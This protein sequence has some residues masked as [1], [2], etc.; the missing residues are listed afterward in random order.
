VGRCL[1]PSADQVKRTL[2]DVSRLCNELGFSKGAQAQAQGLLILCPWHTEKTP[3]CSVTLSSDRTVRVKCFACG[4]SGDVL[5][6]IARARGLDLK[7]EFRQVL[8]E[9][10]RI[11]TAVSS[12]GHNAGALPPKADG[13]D[14][15]DDADGTLSEALASVAE[16]LL[17]NC[18]LERARQ[19]CAYLEARGLIEEA[20][21][22]GW[23]A[24]PDDP[25]PLVHVV[26]RVLM[27]HGADV[28]QRSGF[29]GRGG[30][31]VWP[32]HRVLIPWRDPSGRVTT[33][34]RRLARRASKEERAYVFPRGGAAEWP[35]GVDT[36]LAAASVA[37]A[38]VEGAFDALA[39]RA[40]YRK[41]HVQRVVVGV[42][43]VANFR[44]AWAELSRGRHVYIAFDNDT[45]GDRAAKPLAQTLYAAG[46]AR[47]T[48]ARPTRAKDWAEQFIEEKS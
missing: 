39:L 2:V 32:E 44:A 48:R 25:E 24:L 18:P 11:A 38:F 6:L 4:A 3:S 17:E 27:S 40:L 10:Q 9:A 8:A 30:G 47:V 28:W 16:A 35:Y 1:A 29:G 43:G 15:A 20:L 7:V 13:A 14:D 12:N 26:D 42:P 46:A 36:A 22:D 34:Q 33:L 19:A 41:R 23:G 21:A 45:A 37:I 5:T 31:L